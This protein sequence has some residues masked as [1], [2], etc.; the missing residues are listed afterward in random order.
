MI[1]LVVINVVEFV[2]FLGS[3]LNRP[4]M[5]VGVQVPLCGGQ[6]DAIFRFRSS[7]HYVGALLQLRPAGVVFL[8]A[9][10]SSLRRLY[11]EGSA[12]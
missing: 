6:R 10:S 7:G 5:Q 2:F 1:I 11:D 4:E 12:P 9:K 8:H 3:D